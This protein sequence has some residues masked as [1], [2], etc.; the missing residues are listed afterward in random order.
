MSQKG[1]FSFVWG[2]VRHHVILSRSI[3][4]VSFSHLGTR[5]LFLVRISILR[6][7]ACSLTQFLPY[8][9]FVFL[10]FFLG[11]VA[12]VWHNAQSDYLFPCAVLFSPLFSLFHVETQRERKRPLGRRGEKE[13]K[14]ERKEG[15]A[16]AIALVSLCSLVRMAEDWKQRERGRWGGVIAVKKKREKGRISGMKAER[17]Q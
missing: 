4:L 9:S 1:S 2:Y 5:A 14:K 17:G 7:A 13:R 12:F 10:S 8:I 3:L 15:I 11:S 16:R 6:V